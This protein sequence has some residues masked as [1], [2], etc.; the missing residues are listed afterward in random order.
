VNKKVLI[1]GGNS[2]IGRGLKYYFDKNNYKVFA[3]ARNKKNLIKYDLNNVTKK[4]FLNKNFFGNLKF[5][6]VLFVAAITTNDKE[7][8]NKFCTFGNLDYLSYIKLL[9][10]N[11]FSQIKTFE[12]LKK[13]NNLKKKSKIIFFSSLAGS[14][15]NRGELPHNKPYGNMFYRISKAAL[16]CAVKNLS[17]DFKKNY[18]IVSMHPGY[19]KTK[20]GGKKADLSVDYASRKIFKTI[21]DLKKKDNGKFLDLKGKKILW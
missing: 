20:S 17:Y 15:A 1:I 6:Y 2:G 5:D 19:V 10:I 7:V 14:I 8:K 18:I 12:N 9:S 4:K 21:I 3:T 16:N 11:C 13:N